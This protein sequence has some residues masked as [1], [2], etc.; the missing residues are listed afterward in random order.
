M[1]IEENK[2]QNSE[3][4]E[5]GKMDSDD[6]CEPEETKGPLM[7]VKDKILKNKIIKSA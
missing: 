6:N 2:T 7:H 1:E 5:T 4:K 3:D